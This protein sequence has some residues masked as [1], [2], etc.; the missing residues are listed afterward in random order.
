MNATELEHEFA[1]RAVPYSGGLQ[2]LGPDDALAL[3]RRA[4][5]EGVP[6]LGV[7]GMLLSERSTESPI[8]HIADFSAAVARGDG[9]WGPAASFIAERR[10]LGLGFEVVLRESDA[11]AP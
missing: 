5:E 10:G 4:A 3:V 7:D 1:P 8:E 11:P 2:L 6:V 9:C